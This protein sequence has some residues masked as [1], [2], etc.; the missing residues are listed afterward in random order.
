MFRTY[1]QKYNFFLDIITLYSD[2][3]EV[4]NWV[5]VVKKIGEESI[6]RVS[7]N[8]GKGKQKKKI[9]LGAILCGAAIGQSAVAAPILD[10]M[11]L[12]CPCPFPISYCQFIISTHVRSSSI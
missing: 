9:W 1:R 7:R 6:I 5:Q 2:F 3:L 11:A 10:Q 4:K 12:T 8:I